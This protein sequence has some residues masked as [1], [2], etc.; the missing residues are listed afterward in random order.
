MIQEVQVRQ[1]LGFMN[2]VHFLICSISSRVFFISYLLRARRDFA[3]R[4]RYSP[5]VKLRRS[6][7]AFVKV[8]F[9]RALSDAARLLQRR[10]VTLAR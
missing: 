3:V 10:I 7:R 2:R 5:I 8:N 9:S 6:P 1:Q 4:K